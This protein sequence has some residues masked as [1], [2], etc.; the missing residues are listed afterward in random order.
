MPQLTTEDAFAL[1]L[2]AQHPTVNRDLVALLSDN[3]RPIGAHLTGDST[4][5]QDALY[6]QLNETVEMLRR[7]ALN[8][9]KRKKALSAA[10]HVHARR[11]NG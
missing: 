11:H 2:I 7:W 4:A 3:A 5:A 6:P 10:G 1:A 8:A 9:P